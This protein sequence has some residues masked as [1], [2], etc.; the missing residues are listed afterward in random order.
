MFGLDILAMDFEQAALAL[1]ARAASRARPCCVVVTP[2]VDHLT[3]LDR[4]TPE[5]RAMYASADAIF[6]DGMPLVWASRHFSDT[7]LPG[8]VTGADLF[9]R[10]ARRAGERGWPI[11]V[12]GGQP[13]EE[14]ALSAGLAARFPGLRATVFAPSM[15]FDPEG[16]EGLEALRRIAEVR[17][18][19]VFACLGMPKQE[20]WAMGHR[21]EIDA[22]VVMCV[23]AAL[24]FA[25][26]QKRRAPAWMQRIG[27]EWLWRLLSEPRRLWRRY[28]VQSLR[29]ARLLRQ[30]RADAIRKQQARRP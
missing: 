29:F 16:A 10:L 15:Q 21:H 13:G 12:L 7:P 20:R 11:F 27:F 8:R 17:P 5:F 6:A 22:S 25:L 1:E 2:N 23:G 30:E 4:A 24:E 14:A 9:V 19:I 3:R 28:L 26:G 18:A